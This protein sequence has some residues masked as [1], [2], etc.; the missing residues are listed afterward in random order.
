MEDFPNKIFFEMV[1]WKNSIS[2]TGYFIQLGLIKSCE[3][4]KNC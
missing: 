4:I 3:K 1:L 2:N